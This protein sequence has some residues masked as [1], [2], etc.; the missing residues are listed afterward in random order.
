MQNLGFNG[1]SPFNPLVKE[2]YRLYQS[3]MRFP[4]LLTVSLAISVLNTLAQDAKTNSAAKSD[5]PIHITVAEAK[6][7]IGANAVVTGVIAEVNKA[8]KLVRLNFEKPF[9]DNVFTAVIFARNTN[10]FPEVDKLK[11]KT[12]EVSGKVADYRNRPQIV[13]NTTNQIKV[14]EKEAK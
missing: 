7:H 9:P 8:E 13:V 4:I 11:G 3:G 14:I 6:N 12:V 10:D 5:A 1:F 2:T